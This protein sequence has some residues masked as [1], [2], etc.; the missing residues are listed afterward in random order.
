MGDRGIFSKIILAVLPVLVSMGT[1][2]NA[3]VIGSLVSLCLWGTVIFFMGT[4]KWFPLKLWPLGILLWMAAV[5]QIG[6]YLFHLAPLWVVSLFLLL[7]EEWVSSGWR[8][9]KRR[10][11]GSSGSRGR[12]AMGIFW[13]GVGFLLLTAYL[14]ISQEILGKSYQIWSFRGPVGTFL[15]LALAAAVW[16]NQPGQEKK[17]SVE[18]DK[19]S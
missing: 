13:C 1:L 10:M 17:L 8:F 14:G 19:T 5:A 3:L 15:L 2:Q 12:F 6:Y 11:P 18:G 4:R 9:R 7:P 16:Q